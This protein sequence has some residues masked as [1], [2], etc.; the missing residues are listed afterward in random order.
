MPTSDLF[1][2]TP[3]PMPQ[4]TGSAI[5]IWPD[6]EPAIP[7]RFVDGFEPF[8]AFAR[9]A[10]AD[11]AVLAGDLFALWDFVA[12][13]PE[14]LES[15]VTADAAARFLGNAIAVVHPAATWHMASEP[16]VGTSTMSVPVV[17]LLRTIVERPQ[18]REPFREVLASWP[19]ADH[20][21]QE[22]AALGAQ[23]FAVDIDFVVT[24]EPFVRPALEI[25]VFLDDDGRVIDYGSRWAGGSPPDDAYSRVSH[26]ER[27]A[28]A[29]AAVDALIDHLETWYVV[30]VD[31]AV[32]PSGSRVVHLR[33][34][35][36][37]PITLTMSA[38]G[39]SIGIEAGAL[40]SEIVPSCTCDACDESADSVAEQVE[41]TLLSIAAGGLREVFP[42]GQRRSAHIRIRTVDGGGRS[43]AGEP[44]RSVPAARLDAAAEL[45]GSLSD[46]W[47]PAWSLRPGRE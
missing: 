17:G 36:G 15:A 21:S 23:D 32:E 9:D 47:W 40:F 20:D 13:H 30:D 8:A 46:G 2:G 37:A 7:A 28:P 44:G 6:A 26:P 19:Q 3:V 29:L 33:P 1:P 45:L 16:E 38:T 34:T 18:Q 12:A 35:T 42:V 4:A 14:L 25:P 10:G 11:P 31:R 27:F 43:S 5:M 22:L 41:E 39:E 24:P